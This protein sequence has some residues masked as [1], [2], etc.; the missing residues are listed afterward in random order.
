MSVQRVGIFCDFGLP[1]DL[2]MWA[3]ELA[4]VGFSDAVIGLDHSD[5][6]KLQM[7]ASPQ[8]IAD[9]A[10]ELR[11]LDIDCHLMSWPTPNERD[12]RDNVERI[13]PLAE[14][15]QVRSW[16]LD[17]E[18]GWMTDLDADGDEGTNHHQGAELLAELL[19]GFGGLVGVTGYGYLPRSL[20]PLIL[21][22]ADYLLPQAYSIWQPSKSYTLAAG[23]APGI[24]QAGS[25]RSWR[26]SE[27]KMRPDS[28]PMHMIAGLACYYQ[29][30]PDRDQLRSMGDA[31]Q[32]MLN[33]N[34]CTEAWYWSEKGMRGRWAGD[35]PQEREAFI[36]DKALEARRSRR[37]A[38]ELDEQNTL[39]SIRPAIADANA[40]DFVQSRIV[41]LSPDDHS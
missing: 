41:E 34:E 4:D 21:L 9:A 6:G 39:G 13:R 14:D 30:R 5:D 12:I 26:T 19:D 29:A 17:V 22:V 18:H 40:L 2:A 10:H 32:A 24:L 15:I 23:S 3:A 1:A 38:T 37:L 16:L 8:R 27:R 11:L 36:R 25:V 7:L 35:N 20:H 28:K 33:T 31:W